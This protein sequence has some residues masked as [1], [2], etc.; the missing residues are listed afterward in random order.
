M[1]WLPAALFVVACGATTFEQYGPAVNGGASTLRFSK[2]TFS[3]ANSS[4]G[5]RRVFPRY[6]IDGAGPHWRVM[7]GVGSLFFPREAAGTPQFPRQ[8]RVVYENNLPNETSIHQHGLTPPNNLDGVPY[9]SQV[10]IFPGRSHLYVFELSRQNGGT[11]FIHSHYGWDHARG[12][13]APL[14]V[15]A[16]MPA[17]YPTAVSAAVDAAQN[18]VLFLEDFCS[19][20][21]DSTPNLNN[22]EDGAGGG[23][24]DVGSTF[25][26]LQQGW[27]D[28]KDGWQYGGGFNKAGTGPYVGETQCMGAG[29]GGDVGWRYQL[30]NGATLYDPVVVKAAPGAKLRLR[31]INSATMSDYL[32]QCDDAFGGNTLIAVDGQP[33]VPLEGSTVW[34]DGGE[35][36]WWIAVAQRLDVLLTA[37]TAPGYYY[38]LARADGGTGDDDAG[39]VIGGKHLQ[40]GIVIAVGDVT[41]LPMGAVPMATATGVGFMGTPKDGKPDTANAVVWNGIAQEAALRAFTPL[42]PKAADRTYK[43]DLTGDNG[44]NSINGKGYQL[45]PMQTL[46]FDPNPAPLLV[47][48]GQRICIVV[49]NFNADA[50]AMHLHGHSFQVTNVNGVDVAGAMR[51]TLLVAK[52]G[53]RNMTLCFDADNDGIW[54]FHCHMGF[55][56]AAGMLTTVEYSQ[57]GT[58][59]TAQG[60]SIRNSCPAAGG[61]GGGGGACGDS[62]GS[63]SGFAV[64]AGI[65]GTELIIMLYLTLRDRRRRGGLPFK[66]AR[67]LSPGGIEMR[68]ESSAEAGGANGDGV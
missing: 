15:D 44:F 6:V 8:F 10:P 25:N 7:D 64:V 49:S 59:P 50:H 36:G 34:T 54:P 63:T 17:G 23:C 18:V 67:L 37:P 9:L 13:A 33:V 11:Y 43:V 61:G 39:A 28:E 62:P 38:I 53:C 26:V 68:S 4:A 20:A 22:P 56:L 31:V 66:G 14:I 12:L 1:L 32:V 52:G 60:D 46:P 51:D 47:T 5:T 30:A 57:L 3:V 2:R 24:F 45:V 41:G 27:N 19:Y 16:P 29:T 40:S 65:L 35:K 48:R 42:A 55:H 58:A 21:M